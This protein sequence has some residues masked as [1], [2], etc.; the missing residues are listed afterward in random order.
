MTALDGNAKNKIN[1]HASIHP[2]IH[3]SVGRLP[4]NRTWKEKSDNFTVE[5]P[6]RLSLNQGIKLNTTS[7]QLRGQDILENIMQWEG[8]LT[9]AVF[10]RTHT[11]VYK[12]PGLHLSKMSIPPRKGGVCHDMLCYYISY[13]ILCYIKYSQSE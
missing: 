2:Y 12:I 1:I 6:G 3:L 10:L 7:D 13:Y 5:E 8:H 4:K 11:S 9:S